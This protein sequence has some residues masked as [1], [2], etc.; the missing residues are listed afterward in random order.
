M[1]LLG[2][3]VIQPWVDHPYTDRG[4][5]VNPYARSN[6]Y[7]HQSGWSS[8]IAPGNLPASH[9]GGAAPR[10]QRA[11]GGRRRKKRRSHLGGGPPDMYRHIPDKRGRKMDIDERRRRKKLREDRKRRSQGLAVDLE[12]AGVVD[13][14][15]QGQKDL[16]VER[17]EGGLEEHRRRGERRDRKR[18]ENLA[19]HGSAEPWN[20]G[21]RVKR[22]MIR[23]REPG[24]FKSGKKVSFGPQKK[25]RAAA[26]SSTF[27]ISGRGES[28][29]VVSP[30]QEKRVGDIPPPTNAR[31]RYGR[32]S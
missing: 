1:R 11:R 31:S 32:E 2:I 18:H 24:Y 7:V 22:E 21:V 14:L 19:L 28:S 16:R 6:Q 17:R 8:Q 26:R 20:I 27:D 29:G 30:R 13:P 15:E 12:V 4:R 3:S 25:K 10:R 5:Y 23:G 9:L